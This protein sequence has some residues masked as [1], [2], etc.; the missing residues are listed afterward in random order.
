MFYLY[1]LLL[2]HFLLWG[3]PCSVNFF[4]AFAQENSLLAG[5]PRS[6]KWRIFAQSCIA[7]FCYRGILEYMLELFPF[8]IVIFAGVF[9]SAAFNRLHLPWVIALILGGILIG[10]N[11]FGV[12]EP[13]ET[14]RLLSDIGLVF[15][16]FMAGLE[17]KLG[18]MSSRIK[19]VSSIAAINGLIP[20]A[21]GTGIGLLLGLEVVAALLLGIIFI[22]S[23][24]GVVIPSLEASGILHTKLVRLLSQ[25][26][27][28]RMLR[29]LFCSRFFSSQSNQL[30]VF[31]CPSFIH[32]Y[33]L[34]LCSF[35]SLYRKFESCFVKVVSLTRTLSSRSYAPS[36]LSSLEQ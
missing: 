9:F 34:L 6:E 30:R 15:L 25:R 33:L 2:S 7:I 13:N 5:S 10:P 31:H 17:I 8:F 32:F 3:L 14:T 4:R 22:S 19:K 23:S 16:M 1:A 20:F 24:I 21:I 26:R 29:V 12:F 35:G 36:L 28:L 27:C 11:V 18:G